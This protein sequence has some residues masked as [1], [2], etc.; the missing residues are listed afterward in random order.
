MCKHENCNN[1]IRYIKSVMGYWCIIFRLFQDT[2]LLKLLVLTHILD[3][4]KPMENYKFKEK[5]NTNQ[6]VD[7]EKSSKNYIHI[8]R[9]FWRNQYIKKIQQKCLRTQKV[10]SLSIYI[11]ISIC[12]DCFLSIYRY[13]KIYYS[14]RYLLSKK[15]LEN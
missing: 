8:Y 14:Q 13:R 2:F 4:L 10:A 15:V 1:H 11:S 6:K 12:I 9:Y 3:K 5:V 7:F